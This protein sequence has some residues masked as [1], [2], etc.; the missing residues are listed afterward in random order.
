MGALLAQARA[1]RN[2][3]VALSE[4]MAQIWQTFHTVIPS[5][6]MGRICG[7]QSVALSSVG[8]DQPFRYPG[9]PDQRLVRHLRP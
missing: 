2:A 3:S 7:L 4:G 5:C 8:S 1:E 6:P 9:L